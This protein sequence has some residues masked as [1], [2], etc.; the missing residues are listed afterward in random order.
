[1]G[2]PIIHFKIHN[3]SIKD[4]RERKPLFGKD[5][6]EVKLMSFITDDQTM[7][8]D[9]TAMLQTNDDAAKAAILRSATTN[10]IQSHSFMELEGIRDNSI[11]PLPAEGFDLYRSDRIPETLDLLFLAIEIDKTSRE[12]AQ[13]VEAVLGSGEFKSLEGSLTSILVGS[14][15]AIAIGQKVTQIL[16]SVLLTNAK[17]N[18][19]DLIG[20]V[21]LSLN[22]DEHYGK[23]SWVN[24]AMPD[25]SNNMFISC[26]IFA[27]IEPPKRGK[28]SPKVKPPAKTK[29]A[30]PPA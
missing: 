24:D 2:A 16:S 17:G 12:T 6:A 26:S 13:M 30:P 18:R 9:L 20:A 3:I 25:L 23:G 21:Y 27:K 5:E 19:D 10:L 11:L 1:M 14:N 22:K 4:N 15:P 28:G 8:P 7:L 29:P